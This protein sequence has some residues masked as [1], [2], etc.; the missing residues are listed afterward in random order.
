M[1]GRPELASNPQI[2][3]WWTA[4]LGEI[5][6]LKRQV[7]A[8]TSGAGA[9]IITDAYGNAMVV[10]GT[11]IGQIV[12]VGATHGQAGVQVGTGLGSPSAPTAGLGVQQGL[13]TTTIATTAGSVTATVAS[14][15]G[16][17]TGMSIGAANV[18]DPSSGTATPAIVPG[19]T[20]S[21]IS[22]TTITLSQNAAE[23]GSALYCA[24]V[25]FRSLA[26]FSYP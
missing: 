18:S 14:S 19:T 23:T 10:Q 7:A 24:A 9:G 1:P 4:V 12:T 26:L 6:A 13:V 25:F 11:N 21:G 17:S 15:A 5:S 2:G 3:Q 20:I 22:G 16:M 8:L